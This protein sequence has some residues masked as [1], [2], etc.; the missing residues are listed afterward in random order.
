MASSLGLSFF[1]HKRRAIY[2]LPEE[3]S[4]I[5]VETFME[6]ALIKRNCHNSSPWVGKGVIYVRCRD[7]KTILTCF[8]NV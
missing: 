1:T 3:S 5:N 4:E 8:M 6:L 2:I 7:V